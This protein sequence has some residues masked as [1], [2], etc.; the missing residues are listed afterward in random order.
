MCRLPN[1]PSI[2]WVHPKSTHEC[3]LAWGNKHLT[4]SFCHIVHIYM[5]ADLNSHP[6]NSSMPFSTLTI[7][8]GNFHPFV[9]CKYETWDLCYSIKVWSGRDCHFLQ[10]IIAPI[11]HNQQIFLKYLVFSTKAIHQYCFEYFR[12][13][14]N[15]CRPTSNWKKTHSREIKRVLPELEIGS[16]DFQIFVNSSFNFF[17]KNDIHFWEFINTDPQ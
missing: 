2:G 4:R 9:P 14:M 12:I 13:F 5:W 16:S 3:P 15:N 7:L 6:A 17:L 1:N 8:N 10:H 11:T